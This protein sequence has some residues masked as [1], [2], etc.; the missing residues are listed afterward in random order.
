MQK[1]WNQRSQN[2][3]STFRGRW[4]ECAQ[5]FRECWSA[6]L[7]I[8]QDLNAPECWIGLKSNAYSCTSRGHHCSTNAV[9]TPRT[10]T[11]RSR[12]KT[13]QW[14]N[15]STLQRP[16]HQSPWRRGVCRCVPTCIPKMPPSQS[17]P[18]HC[19]ELQSSTPTNHWMPHSWSPWRKGVCRCIPTCMCEMHTPQSPTAHC[20]E[21][22]LSTS[23]NYGMRNTWS[24]W[25]RGVY[26][27]IPMCI[28]QMHTP[29]SPPAHHWESQS[30]TPHK[31]WMPFPWSPWLRGGTRFCKVSS[32]HKMPPF[33]SPQFHREVPHPSTVIVEG[34]PV[35]ESPWW[36]DGLGRKSH[37][38]GCKQSTSH[39]CCSRC[40]FV[41]SQRRCWR[42]C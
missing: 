8:L 35:H 24:P 14:S 22:Q 34:I 10:R 17:P 38:L 21:S 39:C 16:S 12:R 36:T 1:A 9:S 18:V 32:I 3:H 37:P 4:K 15:L 6:M 2:E 33:Q 25:W 42:S 26:R 19:W 13:V 7:L 20:W 28:H 29:Q 31:N 40:S 11:L 5:A 23:S 27:C 41:C 30:S